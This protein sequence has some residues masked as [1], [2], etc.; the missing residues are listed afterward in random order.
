MVLQGDVHKISNEKHG[1]QLERKDELSSTQI[2][3]PKYVK[4]SNKKHGATQ[5]I[6]YSIIEQIEDWML[7]RFSFLLATLR[8]RKTYRLFFVAHIAILWK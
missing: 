8:V 5:D 6:C 1:K 3:R 4:T 7:Q 2:L